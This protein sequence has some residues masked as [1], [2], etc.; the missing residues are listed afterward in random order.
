MKRAFQCITDGLF[1]GLA[2]KYYHY[3]SFETCYKILESN[4]IWMSD[5]HYL[6]DTTEILS[7]KCKVFL[8]HKDLSHIK[9]EKSELPYR[10]LKKR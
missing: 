7:C 1:N 10:S 4:D 9:V 6:N 2:S 5:I 8:Q 3:T